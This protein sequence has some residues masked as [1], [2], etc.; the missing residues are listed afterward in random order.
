MRAC[1]CGAPVTSGKVC[2]SCRYLD[3]K[4]RQDTDAIFAL[5]EQ[6]PPGLSLNELCTEIHGGPSESRRRSMLRTMQILEAVGRVRR[7]WRESDHHEVRRGDFG[8]ARH[9]HRGGGGSHWVYCL[10]ERVRRA[11]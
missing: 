5:R 10:T 7:Y 8:R 1:D 6:G 4:G 11:A 3:G 2:P 9:L